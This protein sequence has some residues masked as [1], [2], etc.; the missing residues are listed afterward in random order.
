MVL[1][2]V[3]EDRGG[4]LDKEVDGGIRLV[5]KDV[6]VVDGTDVLTVTGDLLAACC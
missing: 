6:A 5:A 2:I 4:K 1:V 3:V